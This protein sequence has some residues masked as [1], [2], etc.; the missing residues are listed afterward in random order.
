MLCDE[1]IN[2][3]FLRDEYRG[4]EHVQNMIEAAQKFILAPDFALAADGLTDN[5]HELDKI[6]PFCRLP[7][8]L[9]WFEFAHQDR[10]H[11]RDAPLHYPALQGSPSRVGFLCIALDKTLA[12]WQTTLCWSL[13]K[14]S[15]ERPGIASGFEHHLNA[16]PMTVIYNTS[17]SP[18]KELSDYIEFEIA[19]FDLGIP[20]EILP[21]YMDT[22]ARSDWAG[23]VR[24]LF[25]V[26]GLLNARNVA[27]T[28]TVDYAKLN[29]KRRAGNKPPLSSHTL[30]K[31]RLVHKASLTGKHTEGTSGEVRSHFVRGHFK[32]RR[33]G[34]F[35]WGP[36]MRGNL[37]RGH[38]SKDYEIT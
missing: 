37:A 10:A 2:S 4:F 29:R 7:Y 18:I 8:P 15:T 38:V 5:Y 24:Y 35:W 25:S 23:E 13:K 12:H 34:H 36:H 14:H 30:L 21:R 20:E 26:L 11:W 22:L 1:I 16:S 32:T 9:C 33:T 3:K 17:K 27:E 28:E 19:D 6:A 31:V